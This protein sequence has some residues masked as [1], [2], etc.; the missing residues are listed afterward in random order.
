[1]ATSYV[2]TVT[3]SKELMF[4]MVISER[5][6]DIRKGGKCAVK[7]VQSAACVGSRDASSFRARAA[8][9]RLSRK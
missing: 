2:K 8:E 1:M 6:A 3:R 9:Y 5:E 7:A 4:A